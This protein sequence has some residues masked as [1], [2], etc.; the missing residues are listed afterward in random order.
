VPKSARLALGI[1]LIAGGFALTLLVDVI[2][3]I[4]AI[5]LGA[6]VMPWYPGMGAGGD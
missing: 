4:A 5:V 1:A 3:G 2:A 6:L